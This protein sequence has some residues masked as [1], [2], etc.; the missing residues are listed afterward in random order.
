MSKWFHS[1]TSPDARRVALAAVASASVFGAL[2]M[3]ANTASA[4]PTAATPPVATMAKSAGPAWAALTGEQRLAL[5]PLQ[6]DWVGLDGNSKAK[7]LEVASR[8][9]SMPPSERERV[10]QRMADW[11]RLTPTERGQAR[12]QFQEARQLSP[13]DRQARWDE[14]SSLPD[15]AR[16][17]L[18][19]RAKPVTQA[20]PSPGGQTGAGKPT[21]MTKAVGA[22]LAPLAEKRN[23]VRSGD[24]GAAKSVSPTVVQARPG[25]T[26]VLVTRTAPPPN[27]QQPGLPKIAA[28]EGFVN[29]STLLPKRGAQGAA[30]RTAAAASDPAASP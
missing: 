7:W 22:K 4:Q 26:T 16:R 3:A 13:G 12:L 21:T 23:V 8:F 9:P 30:V 27:H 20:A 25:A 5:A 19:K 11:S 10:R 28:T 2:W 18:A 14:Y 29:P 17:E 6:R 15:E 24:A 1:A